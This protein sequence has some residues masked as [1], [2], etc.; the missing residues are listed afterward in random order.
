MDWGIPI[1]FVVVI[2]VVYFAAKQVNFKKL[3]R[4]KRKTLTE[5]QKEVERYLAEKIKWGQDLTPT[6]EIALLSLREVTDRLDEVS[7]FK[8]LISHYNPKHR[9]KSTSMFFPEEIPIISYE[10][11]GTERRISFWTL[12]SSNVVRDNSRGKAAD[13]GKAKPI[14]LV[15]FGKAMIAF[16]VDGDRGVGVNL[17]LSDLL[18]SLTT[19]AEEAWSYLQSGKLAKI[20][21]DNLL[22]RQVLMYV[23]I[24]I[25]VGQLVFFF[26]H[27]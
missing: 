9:A 15:V 18:L 1:I 3:F 19:T 23:I 26:F 27:V 11:N 12:E 13:L 17:Q 25:I 14:S 20:Y 24:G 16:E 10:K 21:T 2:I 22:A 8:S 4:K 6:E 7:E 5:S